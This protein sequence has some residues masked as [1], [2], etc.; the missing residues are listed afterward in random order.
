MLDLLSLGPRG[1]TM[2]IS[3]FDRGA[4]LVRGTHVLQIVQT[5]E[6]KC[7]DVLNNPALARTINRSVA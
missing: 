4:G 1:P 7:S 5:A 3:G 6:F 2:I